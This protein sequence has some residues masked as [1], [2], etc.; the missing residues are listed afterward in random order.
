MSDIKIQTT[1]DIISDESA[2][3]QMTAETYR[4]V[5]GWDHC[6]ESVT[7]E[8]LVKLD[9]HVR[10]PFSAPHYGDA[11][12]FCQHIHRKSQSQGLDSVKET[13]MARSPSLVSTKQPI[14]FAGKPSPA[15]KHGMSMLNSCKKKKPCQ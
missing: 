6:P 9:L 7:G 8:R 2:E 1:N 11:C 14:A 12:L 4:F 10:L 13:T 15:K 3:P 5:M